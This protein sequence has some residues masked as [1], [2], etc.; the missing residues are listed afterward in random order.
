M[1]R[2]QPPTHGGEARAFARARGGG[3]TPNNDDNVTRDPIARTAASATPPPPPLPDGDDD[4]PR[5][6]KYTRSP[7]ETEDDESPAMRESAKRLRPAVD[8]AREAA[9]SVASPRV[10]AQTRQHKIEMYKK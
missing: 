8:A 4:A 3:G 1:K 10:A 9:A 7:A 2:K 5:D 6:P